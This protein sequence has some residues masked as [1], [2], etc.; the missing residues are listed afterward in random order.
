M[1][2]KISV[3]ILPLVV[4]LMMQQEQANAQTTKMITYKDPQGRFQINYPTNWTVKPNIN[5]FQLVVVSFTNGAYTNKSFASV[6]IVI[7]NVPTQTDPA[8]YMNLNGDPGF[9]LFQNIECVK[10]KIDSN[11]AC[12]IVLTGNPS[13]N[14]P[15]AVLQVASYVDK[16]MYTFTMAGSQD[17]FDTVKPIF[18]AMLH[19]FTGS[20]IATGSSGSNSGNLKH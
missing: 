9:S 19:S 18:D 13:G 20:G 11:K 17:D 14:L 4:L 3:I 16:K 6:N 12:D 2:L 15:V 5:R 10:Y 7:D 8:L 1:L